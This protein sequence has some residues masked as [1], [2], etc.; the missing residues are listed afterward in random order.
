MIQFLTAEIAFVASIITVIGLIWGPKAWPAFYSWLGRIWKA[1]SYPIRGTERRVD[2]LKAIQEKLSE[3]VVEIS[4]KLDALA[5]QFKPNGGSSIK[6][7]LNRI[8]LK[9]ANNENMTNFIISSLEVPVFRTDSSGLCVWAS[10][11]YC[12]LAD[13]DLEDLLGWG[14]LSSIH[15]DDADNVR[16][17]WRAA[18]EERRIFEA[19]FRVMRPSGN[20]LEVQSRATP[21]Y[22][23]NK[24]AGWVGSWEIIDGN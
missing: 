16:H 1:I 8:E 11:A 10:R 18:V 14:W 7:S 20:I 17:K 2:E 3:G 23:S 15:P 13:R 5:E 22:F 4:T 6:D 12:A 9:Q 19:V 21:T 24:V